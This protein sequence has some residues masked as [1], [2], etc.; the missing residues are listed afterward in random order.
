MKHILLLPITFL[1]ILFTG[2]GDTS[3]SEE[4]CI[5]VSYEID[6]KFQWEPIDRRFSG[7]ILI[8]NSAILRKTPLSS[9]SYGITFELC[10]GERTTIAIKSD[11]EENYFNGEFTDLPVQLP[12]LLNRQSSGEPGS[13]FDYDLRAVCELELTEMPINGK[14]YLLFSCY[15][16]Q[17]TWFFETEFEILETV[18]LK[19]EKF[20]LFSAGRQEFHRAR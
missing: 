12:Q 15:D 9:N 2:C 5:C 17:S 6:R 8:R 11:D 13:F 16:V 20:V 10:P 14:Y 19:D 18:S 4:T 3:R 7:M 1:L